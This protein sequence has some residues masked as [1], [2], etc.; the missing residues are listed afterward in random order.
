MFQNSFIQLVHLIYCLSTWCDL[1]RTAFNYRTENLINVHQDPL[2]KARFIA[3]VYGGG[4][5]QKTGNPHPAIG[6]QNGT[7]I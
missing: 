6:C 2:K 7:K 5:L 4:A 1:I 3:I